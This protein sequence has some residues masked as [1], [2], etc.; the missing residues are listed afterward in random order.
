LTSLQVINT[1]L[2]GV[3]KITPPTLF[4]DFRGE[5]VELYNKKLFLNAGVFNDFIQD[6]ISISH[7]NVLRGIHGD[8]QTWKLISCLR[9]HFYLL[10]VNNNP[11]S[12]QYKHWE[13]FE[14]SDSDRTMI[15]VPPKF[16]NGHLVLSKYA[17]F[18]YKQST[19]YDRKSQFTIRWN[20]ENYGFKWPIVNP[21]L[22]LRDSS[23]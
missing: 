4:K 7:R 19:N 10:V 20:D 14:L 18:H 12:A 22:S 9:G 16:G 6:D 8:F 23:E 13:S 21:I 15:L 1:K 2:D 17:I 3:L 11:E 5:Y